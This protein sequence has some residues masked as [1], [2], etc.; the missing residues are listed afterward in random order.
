MG[1]W[2]SMLCIWAGSAQNV[3]AHGRLIIWSPGQAKNFVH[4]KT[5]ILKDF[6]PK[7]GLAIFLRVRSPIAG[8]F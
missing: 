3:G 2:A 8:N 4:P 6:W 5:D 7:T 1:S